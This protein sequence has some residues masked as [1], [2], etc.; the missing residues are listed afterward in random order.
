MPL[1]AF[2][3][4]C[5]NFTANVLA[6]CLRAELFLDK[7]IWIA[8]HPCPKMRCCM[9]SVKKCREVTLKT[10]MKELAKQRFGL[11]EWP[12]SSDSSFEDELP[13]GA[14]ASSSDAPAIA[15]V[16]G[17]RAK[18]PWQEDLDRRIQ[19]LDSHNQA[20]WRRVEES[21]E[22]LLNSEMADAAHPDTERNEAGAGCRV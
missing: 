10:G 20:G 1:K 22:C 19:A 12:T 3:S 21:V 14:A 5:R 2:V 4:A 6:H 16:A 9:L 13:A 18:R 8:I 17:P 15:P 11:E 7:I